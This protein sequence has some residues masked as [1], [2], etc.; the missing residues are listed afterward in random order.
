VA[1][2]KSAESSGKALDAEQTR[3]ASA[4][5][6]ALGDLL[7]RGSQT[8]AARRHWQSAA[9]RLQPAAARGE[10]PA[11][12]VLAQ[13]QLRLGAIEDARALAKRIEASPYRH[14]AYADLR[15]RLATDAGAAPAHQ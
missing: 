9:E 5:E 7:A 10:L 14:P 6:L 13:A 4:V 1:T 2:V 8:E 11:M 3:I 15:Q 12:T